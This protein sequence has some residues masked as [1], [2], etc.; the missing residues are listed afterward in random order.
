MTRS[1]MGEPTWTGSLLGAVCSPASVAAW[2]DAHHYLGRARRGIAW[3]DELG[4]AVLANPTAAFLPAD[5]LEL[6]R[7]CLVGERNGGSRQWARIVRWLRAERP[8]VTTVVSYSDPSV[9]HT[10]TLYRACNWRFAPTWHYFRPP[11]T[12]NGSWGPGRPQ[13]AVKCRWIYELRPDPRRE[14]AL[15]IKD[16]A[17]VRRLDRLRDSEAA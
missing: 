5:W 16:A 10:G 11:P 17:I 4:V 6:T 15:Q 7:W 3:A 2:L 8:T 12:G 1:R 13:Q 9:G 14:E